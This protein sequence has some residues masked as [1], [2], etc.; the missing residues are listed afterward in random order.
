M[1]LD[2]AHPDRFFGPETAEHLWRLPSVRRAIASIASAAVFVVALWAT[3]AYRLHRAEGELAALRSHYETLTIARARTA[4]IVRSL[5]A[6]TELDRRIADVRGSGYREV[7]AIV[8]I[9]N[10]LPPNVYLDSVLPG[11]D[12]V[13]VDGRARS[14]DDL[15]RAVLALQSIGGRQPSV[16]SA[17][18]AGNEVHYELELRSDPSPSPVPAGVH[19]VVR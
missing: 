11:K 3:E 16:R 12:A 4:G 1:R 18:Q 2:F 6:F 14:M 17:T 9:G 19:A 8:S 10:A 13:Q 7:S 5:T 15:G